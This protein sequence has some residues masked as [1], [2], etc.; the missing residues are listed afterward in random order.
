MFARMEIHLSADQAAQLAALAAQ[1]G[2]STNALARE[3]ITRFLDEQKRFAD[4]V[5]LGIAA[6]DRGEFIAPDEV[7]AGVERILQA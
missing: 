3:A 1:E 6:G 7:W 2:R 5:S 4:A